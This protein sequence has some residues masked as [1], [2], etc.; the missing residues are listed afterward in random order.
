M[1]A[2]EIQVV[3][4]KTVLINSNNISH[5]GIASMKLF[6]ILEATDLGALK[7][8]LANYLRTSGKLKGIDGA[9]HTLLRYD[10]FF[11]Y[12]AQQLGRQDEGVDAAAE[13]K[14]IDAADLILDRL[15]S[16]DPSPSK[17]FMRWLARMF[18]AGYISFD[19]G[20]FKGINRFDPGLSKKT[21]LHLP[22]DYGNLTT[23]IKDLA[24]K[25]PERKALL[26]EIGLPTDIQQYT[27]VASVLAVP[28]LICNKLEAIKQSKGGS[29]AP[30]PPWV[31]TIEKEMGC[32]KVL[33]KG[34]YII[35][36]TP[37]NSLA[38]KYGF[39]TDDQLRTPLP[40]KSHR[41]GQNLR[42]FKPGSTYDAIGVLGGFGEESDWC[43][44]YGRKGGSIPGNYLPGGTIYTVFKKIQGAY[45]APFMQ[46]WFG[47]GIQVMSRE[48]Q[49]VRVE[50]IEEPLREYLVQ[51]LSECI[52]PLPKNFTEMSYE[53]KKE[54]NSNNQ[55]YRTGF[56][57]M[58][59]P[60]YVITNPTINAIYMALMGP[61]RLTM[62]S[63]RQQF[64]L[65]YIK[66]F[67]KEIRNVLSENGLR[68]RDSGCI[69]KFIQAAAGTPIENLLPVLFKNPVIMLDLESRFNDYKNEKDPYMLPLD[70]M[71][72]MY[73]NNPFNIPQ[74]K[75]DKYLGE[76]LDVT[77]MF[78]ALW[79]IINTDQFY[80][81][82]IDTILN[83]QDQVLGTNFRVALRN[84]DLAPN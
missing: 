13:E 1:A 34:E 79:P 41:D 8:E 26:T 57:T 84:Q 39:S 32:I 18:D 49:Q 81:P 44:R 76:L 63:I 80:K 60:E 59:T 72:N 75:M 48:N 12:K 54:F 3:L 4:I 20:E 31:E 66:L 69:D 58:L 2:I 7:A 30:P 19:D 40:P 11:E 23:A 74:E 24:V 6:M 64:T 56:L 53:E 10:K 83:H 61:G 78:K 35:V 68:P 73:K 43:T 42:R 52:E 15:M 65:P 22:E 51:V 70:M 82:F 33:D 62:R 55:E 37:K 71:F 46:M 28:G 27:D 47:S 16:I 50:N 77:S 38:S 25:N 45:P 14:P 21:Q 36:M 67:R 9:G 29:S 5:I 17:G